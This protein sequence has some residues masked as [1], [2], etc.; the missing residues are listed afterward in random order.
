MVW[1][2]R[3]TIADAGRDVDKSPPSI[4]MHTC[5]LTFCAYIAQEVNRFVSVKANDISSCCKQ[6][7][8]LTLYS[9]TT[10]CV[11]RLHERIRNER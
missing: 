3:E 11:P 2:I 7:L 10:P 9:Q 1:D 4:P 5:E 8:R 6:M